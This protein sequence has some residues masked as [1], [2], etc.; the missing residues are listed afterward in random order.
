MKLRGE[1]STFPRQHC[2]PIDGNLCLL[3]RD[4]R[5]W[6]QKWTLRKLLEFQLA[7]TLNDTG[8][9]DRQ[10]EPAEHWWNMYGKRGSYCLVSSAWTLGAATNGTLKVRYHY[11]KK[12]SHPEIKA[13]VMEVRSG[14]GTVLQS[15]DGPFPPQIESTSGERIIPWI[16]LD[17][18]IQPDQTEKQIYDLMDR[19]PNKPQY[20]DFGYALTGQWFAVIYKTELGF[21]TFGLGWLFL[22]LY[23]PKK[24]FRPAKPGGRNPQM[25]KIVIIPT[26]RAGE[27]DLGARVP[28]IQ[29]LRSKKVA[30]VGLGAIGAPLAIELARNGCKKLH[31]VD[32]DIV[33]PGNSVR[34]P[35]GMSAWGLNKTD[36]LP[37]FIRREFSWTEVQEHRHYIGNLSEDDLVAGDDSLFETI[38]SEVDIMVDATASY[39]ISTML[40]DYCR[41]HGTAL[42][43][44]YASPPVTGGV[45]AR[46]AP[47]S[48]CPTCLEFAHTASAI[49]RAPGFGDEASLQ[50]PPGCAELTFT[51]ASFDLK[52]LSLQAMRLIVDTLE[53]PDASG[54][55]VIYTLSLTQDGK[56]IPPSWCVKE[57][58]KAQGCSC[59]IRR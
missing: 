5:Q 57:L 44:L 4:T 13:V 36:S 8:E 24:A 35:L 18:T 12:E 55:S 47:N 49:K 56:R 42:I 27:L 37:D 40:S 48:G 28:A 6:R 2:S 21:K 58:P 51:G 9:T 10:G 23:G 46:F 32:H 41:I 22:F 14:D 16:Y 52:E 29:N 53:N 59:A 3:G 17:E 39:G 11:H 25:P 54:L 38:L 7:D 31:L 33:E 30:V 20:R 19:F 15:W 43:S 26:Y 34:W 1:P 50:Q 45:V